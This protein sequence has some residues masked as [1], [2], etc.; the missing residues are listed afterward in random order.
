M[1]QHY[2]VPEGESLLIEGPANI[3]VKTGKFPKV[4]ILPDQ[5]EPPEQTAPVLTALEP[6]TVESGS[7]DVTLY[8]TG[9]GLNAESVLIFGTLDEPTTHNEDGTVSTIVKPSLFAPAEVPV[10]V[11]NGEAQSNSL[12]FTFTEPEAGDSARKRRK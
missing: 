2:E 1:A 11:R 7:E 4:G 10:T 6:A 5:P 9:S 8:V 12:I 3:I